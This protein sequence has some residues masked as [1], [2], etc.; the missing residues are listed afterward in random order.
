[1]NPADP[2]AD[3]ERAAPRR[4]RQARD[5]VLMP[6]QLALLGRRVA[7]VALALEFPELDKLVLTAAGERLA[8][9]RQGKGADDALVRANNAAFLA[10]LR[11]PEADRA[12]GPGADDRFV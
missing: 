1:M 9:G 2:R 3:R 6:G 8:V 4:E 11:I 12:I 7:A 10:G 5:H